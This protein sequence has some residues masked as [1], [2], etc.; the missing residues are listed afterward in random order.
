MNK[1][2]NLPPEKPLFADSGKRVVK[3]IASTKDRVRQALKQQ[4]VEE[5]LPHRRKRKSTEVTSDNY[6][7]TTEKEKT[8]STDEKTKPAKKRPSVPPPI[9]FMSLLKLAEKKQFEPVVVESKPKPKPEDFERPMT[10]RQKKEY[11]KERDWK[12][13]RER[14]RKGE[15]IKVSNV[16]PCDSSKS[17]KPLMNKIS[18]INGAKTPTLSITEK[19]PSKSNTMLN[20]KISERPLERSAVKLSEKNAIV[21][22]RRKLEAEKR[23][24]ENMRR[25]IEEE[26]K[27]LAL[28]SK[29]N[30]KPDDSRSSSSGGSK[31][32]KNNSGKLDR[33]SL[34]ISRNSREIKAKQ[35]LSNVKLKQFPPVDVKS[36]QYPPGDVRNRETKLPPKRPIN[37]RRI[38]D[39][40]DEEYDSELDDFI[41]DDPEGETENYSKYISAI[42]GYDKSKYRNFDDDDTNMESNYAQQ[43]KE[44]F[45]STKLG[46]AIHFIIDTNNFIELY[47]HY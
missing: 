44:E 38:Y 12:D 35:S 21:E 2:N 13:K 26:K 33:S 32:V 5:S 28:Q 39:D 40:D 3:D 31:I 41:D 9:D 16:S 30:K 1:Y 14:E 23:E 25:M 29:I 36:R 8:V 24:L 37:P 19:I 6:K 46:K 11:E 17:A 45:V 20:K 42:F 22:E 15:I 34:N 7:D 27:K 47:I 4:E 10:K 18:K 43:L